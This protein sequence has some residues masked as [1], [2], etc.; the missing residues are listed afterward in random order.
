[1]IALRVPSQFETAEPCP[2][3]SADDGHESTRALMAQKK[4][5]QN[6]F[7][8]EVGYQP[9]TYHDLLS[10]TVNGGM[11]KDSVLSVVTHKVADDF[12][13]TGLKQDWG[14]SAATS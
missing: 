4:R 6:R 7:M 5:V 3:F 1:M 9:P 13:A 14:C 8:L 2:A 10:I 11:K 12:L